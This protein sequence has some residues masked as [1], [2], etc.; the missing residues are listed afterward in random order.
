MVI[1]IGKDER[2][3]ENSQTFLPK[4]NPQKWKNQELAF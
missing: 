2:I 4:D 3:R 1:I